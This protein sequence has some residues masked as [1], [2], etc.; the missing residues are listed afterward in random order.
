MSLKTSKMILRGFFPT[1]EKSA[2][3]QFLTCLKSVFDK[4]FLYFLSCYPKLKI[5][6]LRSLFVK[7]RAFEDCYFAWPVWNK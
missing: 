3:Y 2:E 7:L 1:F 4:T 5:F 6:H